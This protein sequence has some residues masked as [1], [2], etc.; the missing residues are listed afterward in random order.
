MQ[1][2]Q[3]WILLKKL[4]QLLL[5][6]YCSVML[7]RQFPHSRFYARRSRKK[8]N[9]ADSISEIK[10][11]ILRFYWTRNGILAAAEINGLPYSD[12]RCHHPVS[13]F[14]IHEG[15]ICNGDMHDLFSEGMSHYNLNSYTQTKKEFCMKKTLP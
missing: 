6:S 10:Q 15:T 14:H 3:S 12:E 2:L 5:C 4:L 11:H 8:K 7:W 9:P 13:A 1:S